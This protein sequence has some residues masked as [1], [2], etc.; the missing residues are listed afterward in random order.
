MSN[1]QP[2]EPQRQMENRL[3]WWR[4]LLD[5]DEGGDEIIQTAKGLGIQVGDD[6][7]QREN[8]AVCLESAQYVIEAD[9][10]SILSCRI[11]LANA[12]FAFETL[13]ALKHCHC[14]D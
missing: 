5:L 11:D 1:V 3:S 13:S 8:C 12:L 7:K 10:N 2:M 14:V 6:V 9:S 4:Y